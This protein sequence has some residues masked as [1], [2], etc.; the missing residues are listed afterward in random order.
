M[1]KQPH[2]LAIFIVTACALQGCALL[3]K[4]DPLRPRYFTLAGD[5][6]AAEHAPSSAAAGQ[7]MRLALGRISSSS[8][9]RERILYRNGDHELGYYDDRRWSE[10]PEVYLRRALV[11]SLFEER[12][13]TRAISGAAPILQAELVAFEEVRGKAPK[14]RMQVAITLD[15]NRSLQATET[16]TVEVEVAKAKGD[17]QANAVAAA[18][19]EA[20]KT[21]VA[22]IADKVIVKLASVPAAP[23]EAVRKEADTAP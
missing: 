12:G 14:V 1:T 21:G 8:A 15:D 5:A 19:G 9:L 13:L 22:Q 2:T 18:F 4:S 3:G 6:E 20:L 16:I 10:R 7:G 11:R 23:A 17:K